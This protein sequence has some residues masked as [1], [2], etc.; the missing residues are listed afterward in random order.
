MIKFNFHFI[1]KWIYNTATAIIGNL[2]I[3][4]K[5]IK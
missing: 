3:K 5:M 4:I 2:F 1:D